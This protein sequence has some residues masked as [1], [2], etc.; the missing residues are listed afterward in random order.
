MGSHNDFSTLRCAIG[1]SLSEAL[2]DPSQHEP[3]LVANIVWHLPRQL[4]QIASYSNGVEIQ[5]GG[6]FVHSR[7]L[8]KCAGFPSKKP[9]SVEIGDLLFLRTEKRNRNVSSRSALLL[10]AKK[11][12]SLPVSVDNKNQHHLYANWPLFEYIRSTSSLNGKKRYVTGPDLYNAAKYLLIGK[13]SCCFNASPS[14]HRFF[15]LGCHCNLLTAHPSYPEISQYRCFA[16]ELTDFILGEAGKPYQSPPPKWTRNWDRVIHDLKVVT[17]K[18][19]SVYMKRASSGES[20][21]RGHGLSFLTGNHMIPGSNLFSMSL[22]KQAVINS[23]GPPK[24]PIENFEDVLQHTDEDGSK[25]G[26]VSIVE[27]VVST[28]E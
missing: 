6:V 10:Q 21:S 26:G 14:C 8:V 25:D 12:D 24:V 16:L 20:L 23:D 18:A 11:F 7:S 22:P 1:K 2:K 5:A 15:H 28:E 13:D 9:E 19:A 4:N 27:F 17:G 3:Q